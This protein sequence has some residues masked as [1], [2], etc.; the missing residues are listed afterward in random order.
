MA[1]PHRPA[2]GGSV[3]AIPLLALVPASC[4][5]A[6][7]SP[8]AEGAPVRATPST[9]LPERY[10]STNSVTAPGGGAWEFLEGL[11][12]RITGAT[13]LRSDLGT[14]SRDDGAVTLVRI[15]FTYTNHGTVPHRSEGLQLPVRL[16]YGPARAEAAADPGYI[17][18]S[19][20]L[21]LTVP[22]TVEAGEAVGGAVSFAV[23]T[24]SMGE[25]AVLAV[26]PRRYTEHLF[27]D[28]ERL[29]APT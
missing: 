14:R 19:G 25:L 13:R 2:G 26:E 24:A 20:Q 4:G 17:G 28:V 23:P 27:T 22:T 5:F 18:T 8:Q 3:L 15:D 16:L 9:V 29:L 11:S 12:V 6:G 7:D 21:T 10:E 1:G